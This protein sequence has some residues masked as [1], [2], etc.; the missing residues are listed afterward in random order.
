[1]LKEN[2]YQ[3]IIMA[4]KVD[5]TLPEAISPQ[6]GVMFLAL[7]KA[8]WAEDLCQEGDLILAADTIVLL[9][10]IIGKPL[11]QDEAYQILAQ[12]NGKTHRVLTGVAIIKAKTSKRMAFYETTY[13]TFKKYSE[14]NI[15]DYIQTNEPYDKAGGYAI[16]GAFGK[17]VDHIQGDRD[18]VI[19]LP[20][21]RVLDEINKIEARI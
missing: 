19:G 21:K 3:P 11:S 7:K 14:K 6:E 8:L 1:M 2:G 12:L 15:R 13:V 5:E 4:P 18:N 17:Y 10:Q 20:L 16:Q 9:D